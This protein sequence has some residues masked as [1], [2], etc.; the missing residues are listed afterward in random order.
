MKRLFL[1]FALSIFLLPTEVF[2]QGCSLCT[3]TA[4][5]LDPSS[6]SGLNNGI[7]Y[8][9]FLPMTILGTVGYLWW[10]SGRQNP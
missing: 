3:K 1:L 8:L 10:K 6:A 2:A 5:E 7:L 9:A 4:S